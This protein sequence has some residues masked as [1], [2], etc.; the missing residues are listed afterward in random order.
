MVKKIISYLMSAVLLFSIGCAKNSD[1]DDLQD[2][3][4]NLENRLSQSEAA[5]QA[6]LLSQ[7]GDLQAVIATLQNAIDAN[8]A[9][10]AA[11]LA[12]Q[13]AELEALQQLVEN[14]ANDIYY[15][16]VISP[17][18]F[19]A[20]LAQG[21]TVITGDV[22]LTAAMLDKLVNVKLI[23]GD[24]EI[25]DD[26]TLDA[27]E[28]VV[29]TMTTNGVV[30]ANKLMSI[31]DLEFNANFEAPELTAVTGDIY[32]FRQMEVEKFM[33][34][35]LGF[36]NSI[37]IQGESVYGLNGNTL[38]IS[39]FKVADGIS[40]VE[41]LELVNVKSG[42]DL[43]IG[44]VSG[45]FR[46]E[47]GR[48]AKITYTAETVGDFKVSG[49]TNIVSIE[50]PELTT[51]NS[52]NVSSNFENFRDPVNEH[53]LYTMSFDKVE[54]VNSYVKIAGNNN[55]QE[56]D[57]FNALT[58]IKAENLPSN[59]WALEINDGGPNSA[60]FNGFNELTDIE[61]SA[62]SGKIEVRIKSGNITAFSK[63]THVNNFDQL[64]IT[65]ADNVS[66]FENLETVSYE[67]K[68]DF[69]GVAGTVNSLTKFKH[70]T[71]WRSTL[72]ICMPYSQDDMAAHFATNADV[73]T[74]F[75]DMINS[76]DHTLASDM[77][78]VTSKYTYLQN[79]TTQKTNGGTFQLLKRTSNVAPYVR[80]YDGGWKY[81]ET[82]SD[83][84]WTEAITGI[85]SACQ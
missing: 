35:K 47:N 16:N 28:V 75:C 17:E 37:F 33:A 34:P 5:L 64:H 50:A 40:V 44:E 62:Y 29:G 13:M 59:T 66:I 45:M 70:F 83:E 65:S 42:S 77:S 56:F 84:F 52:I 68:M 31:G 11:A 6:N 55:L 1:I 20:V 15:G 73:Y 21:A 61:D 39:D 23:G 49:V 24:I 76:L 3:L 80:H 78:S 41:N 14:S 81:D 51:A 58:T 26:V 12:A 79:G 48:A 7:I 72:I 53:G 54:T 4:Q 57:T 46:F 63:I 82:Q 22:V 43:V 19:D 60:K 30:M 67:L 32:S 85:S 8:D 74:P 18:Q 2:Q 69:T 38:V 27:L 25:N 36:A 10:Q 9:A 71:G